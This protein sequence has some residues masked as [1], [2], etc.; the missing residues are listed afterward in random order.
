MPAGRLLYRLKDGAGIG[1]ARV[2]E[3]FKFCVHVWRS[4]EG[5]A[6]E[7]KAATL[8]EFQDVRHVLHAI[9]VNPKIDLAFNLD[10]GA[11]LRAQS[12]GVAQGH[13]NIFVRK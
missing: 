12:D 6:L 5:G 10:V 3:P 9:F 11:G 13:G 2:K 8:G 4:V 7:N 1:P